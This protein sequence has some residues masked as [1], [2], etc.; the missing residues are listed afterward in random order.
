MY[1]WAKLRFPN[2]STG[3]ISARISKLSNDDHAHDQRQAPIVTASSAECYPKRKTDTKIDRDPST[4]YG[5][6]EYV[7][8]VRVAGHKP[9][10]T[11]GTSYHRR[12]QRPAQ[13]SDFAK[14]RIIMTR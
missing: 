4:E 8:T 9:G 3:E 7:S 5:A 1:R 10:K 11:A 14:G 6:L 2:R 12:Y 13:R